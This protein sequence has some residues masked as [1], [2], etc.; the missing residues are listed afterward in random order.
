MS[1]IYPILLYIANGGSCKIAG[2]SQRKDRYISSIFEFSTFPYGNF[3]H[4]GLPLGHHTFTTGISDYKRHLSRFQL[5]SIHQ[6]S[7]LTFVHGSTDDHI[8]DTTEIGY[9]ITSVMGRAVIPY[10]SGAVYTK[11]HRQ[12]LYRYIMH[13][14]VVCTLHKG[15]IHMTEHP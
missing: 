11:Y 9:I 2:M 5:C 8:R 1:G 12:L 15:R 4:G 13:H 6:I 10:Q 7:Q 14:L 3:L